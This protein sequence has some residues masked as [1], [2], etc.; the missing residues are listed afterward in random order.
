METVSYLTINDETKEIAD[1]VSR[2][3]VEDL[4]TILASQNDDIDQMQLNIGSNGTLMASVREIRALAQEAH[5]EAAT[6]EALA[7]LIEER[8]NSVTQTVG[9]IQA[10]TE[11]IEQTANNSLDQIQ[12]TLSAIESSDQQIA[13]IMTAVNAAQLEVDDA[14]ETASA[15]WNKANDAIAA[16]EILDQKINLI[17]NTISTTQTGVDTNNTNIDN[18][19]VQLSAL[20]SIINVI[21]WFTNHSF[22]STD[23]EVNLNKNYYIYNSTTHII[24]KVNP[25]GEENP[26]EQNW[27]E[28]NETFE[29]YLISNVSEINNQ[30]DT[31]SASSRWRILVSTGNN[32]N[33]EGI[34]I[35]DPNNII[36]QIWTNDGISFNS[37]TP[38]SIG[39]DDAHI[40]FDGNNHLTIG[41]SGVNIDS[42]V[43]IGENNETILDIIN[44]LKVSTITIEYG[45]GGSNIDYSDIEEWLMEIPQKEENQYLWLRIF[46]GHSYSHLCIEGTIGPIGPKGD[47]GV[48]IVSV[49][50]SYALNNSEFTIPGDNVWVSS[51]YELA[52][53]G[54]FGT[55]DSNFYDYSYMEADINEPDEITGETGTAD[56]NPNLFTLLVS[57]IQGSWLWV[58]TITEYSNGASTVTYQK[59]Y[60][61]QDGENATVNI[62]PKNINWA[63][64]TATLTVQL[65]VNGRNITPTKYSW[66]K[67]TSEDV[68][69]TDS[70]LNI[71]DFND[72]YNCTVEWE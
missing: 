25:T 54:S 50:I 31:L 22:I 70:I 48:G 49:A 61:A 53:I 5:T 9:D 11:A 38:L 39:N 43:T 55:N 30:I 51:I 24:S 29:D 67:E 32:D 56:F 28:L 57:S 27:Y 20:E 23:T 6:A 62:I 1:L 33:V 15:A 14:N 65:K 2:N 42:G 59:S 19:S 8:M 36:K 40:V 10:Q 58:R 63:Q 16:A 44:D 37:S 52:A 13:S 3:A 35:V 64:N 46:N 34:F 71:T 60:I 21:D 26:S 17:N 66:T 45:L 7:E 12:N 69:S 18:I 4:A 68:I 41:G 72:I 47:T